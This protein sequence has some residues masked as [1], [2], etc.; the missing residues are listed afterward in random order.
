M[1][2]D[3]LH[4]NSKSSRP[5]LLF[6]AIFGTLIILRY[7]HLRVTGLDLST[8]PFIDPAGV[9][10]VY[11]WDVLTAAAFKAGHF[12]LW[13]AYQGFGQPHLGNIQT[14]VFFP[15][16]IIYYLLP[17]KNMHDVYL[18]TRHFLMGFIFF[19]FLM[20][21]RI[22]VTAAIFGGISYGF[23]GY[24]LWFNNLVDLNTQ[25]LTPLLML[26]LDSLVV[27]RS[28]KSILHVVILSF[29]MVLGGHPEAIFVS[30]LFSFLF[31]INTFYLRY[32]F[33]LYKLVRFLFY[34]VL[35]AS[36]GLLLSSVVLIPFFEHFS[37]SV[38]FHPPGIG[39]FHLR[40][41]SILSLLSMGYSFLASGNLPS[42]TPEFFT[43]ST[44]DVFLKSYTF[45]SLPG[46][47]PYGLLLSSMFAVS[48]FYLLF[49][50]HSRTTFF[51]IFSLI[52]VSIT[53]GIF[54]FK[55]IGLFPPFSMMNNSKFY[56]CEIAICLSCLGS[57]GFD[58]MLKS[59]KLNIRFLYIPVIL[60]STLFIIL[61]LSDNDILT[62]SGY[63]EIL[64]VICL[65]VMIYLYI[66]NML[67]FKKLSLISIV[68][69][70]ST[71]L[72]NS[73]NVRP[74][75]D[76]DVNMITKSKW[77]DFIGFNSRIVASSDTFPPNLG[78]LRGLRDLR[79]SDALFPTSYF[80]TICF[81]SNST[82]TDCMSDFYPR[83]FTNLNFKTSSFSKLP[84]FDIN[85]VIT[86]QLFKISGNF[87]LLFNGYYKIYST[88]PT[89]PLDNLSDALSS[90]DTIYYS[91]S[92]YKF[93][94]DKL[95]NRSIS[96]P[97]LY[98]PGWKA[99]YMNTELI[100]FPNQLGFISFNSTAELPSLE[101]YYKPV[102]FKIGLWATISSI[103]YLLFISYRRSAFV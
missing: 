42:F 1:I 4:S 65:S 23:G 31:S 44:S 92:D 35:A 64:C 97:E 72:V 5:Y 24:V 51:L 11:P 10:Q 16:K 19:H 48:S 76:L 47:M 93:T 78:I 66:K 85:F 38:H 100:T 73:F 68:L 81:L 79:S 67:S 55:L 49:K 99:F 13:N 37:R 50:L 77:P 32:G 53:I 74:L 22:S 102:S 94:T 80:N 28:F 25:I 63:F 7:I 18:L 29:L 30:F 83:Y 60:I 90:F 96:V 26:S 58:Y 91:N 39:F 103:L 62:F 34:S 2:R 8:T 6:S 57:F 71:S 17:S 84:E 9:L 101:F 3:S 45:T 75:L 40:P 59:S 41:V 27:K 89:L 87:N 52:T 82:Y 61:S 21:M 98:Y 14:A 46:S 95:Y 70:A 43:L 20:R 54:P 12:P 33:S 88:L 36:T 15:L 56:F 69:I 86:K